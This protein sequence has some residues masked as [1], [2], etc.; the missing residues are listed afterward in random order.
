MIKKISIENFKSIKDAKFDF[1]NKQDIVC[2]IGKNGSGKSNIFKAI[3]YFFDNIS[4][5]YSEEKIIDN[6]NPYIQKCTISILFDLKLLREKSK[7]NPD[8]KSKF[9]IIDNY[10]N[11]HICNP[12]THWELQN[13]KELELT[14]TQYKDGTITWN[15]D[16]KKIRE[17]VK[18]LFPIYYL[19]TRRLDIFTWEHLW[20]IISD[21]SAAMPQKSQEDCRDLIDT[22]FTE[23][24]GDKYRNSKDRIEKV[25]SENGISLDPYHFDS[26]YKNAFSMQFGGEQ[27]LVDGQP[28]TYFSDGTNS[29]N[30][31]ILLSTLIPQISE[32]SCKYPIVL[33]DEPE[34][35]LHSEYISKFVDAI[36]NN[37]KNNSLMF[38]S[39]HS[40]KLISDL[41]NNQVGFQLYKI[42]RIGLH[43]VIH[44][45]NTAWLTDSKHKITVKET[46]CYFYDYLVYLEGET[47]VGLFNNKRLKSLFK[48]LNKVH[49]Y[50]FDGNEE[51]LDTVNSKNINLGT[52]YKIIIDMDKILAYVPSRKKFKFKSDGLNPFK[53]SKTI[54]NI[55]L[56]FFKNN[57]NSIDLKSIYD[58][59]MQCLT[60]TYE[61]HGKQ[62]ISDAEF[63]SLIQNIQE[64]T[65]YYNIIVNWST[66][67]GELI[68]YENINKFL[69]YI[70]TQ[71]LS[72]DLQTQHNTIIAI[73]DNKEKTILTLCEYLGKTEI[74][75][76]KGQIIFDGSN[77]KTI[78]KNKT[79]GWISDWLNYYFD[80]HIDNLDSE[81]DKRAQFKQDFPGL[82]GT[83]QQI[84]SMVE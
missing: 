47:E 39:T 84:E 35:G 18:S 32:I 72:N 80:N 73:N 2:L 8:L 62:Y 16:N 54:E 44:K 7:Y 43:S 53:D 12:D 65:G 51:R 25:F 37:V 77:L 26:K 70:S 15:V 40:P 75:T 9:S 19:D 13:K 1:G 10:L 58:R 82:Y 66:I 4:R 52:K 76:Q 14:L 79:S 61:T 45:M 55:N 30:Y 24:Y 42:N 78:Q 59:I 34:T 49:F 22:T 83:L 5:P 11:E 21:L 29:Y 81:L 46:E 50:S 67:E 3:K 27:F 28:L 41:T 33:L 23:I 31:L 68:T 60:Y 57:T 74:G 64:F 56:R 63:T 48:K 20:K 36:F 69:T 71:T 38:F 17:T 6:S